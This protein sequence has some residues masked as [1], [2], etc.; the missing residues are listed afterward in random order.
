M[1]NN[2][3]IHLLSPIRPDALGRKNRRLGK[4]IVCQKEFACVPAHAVAGYDRQDDDRNLGKD[5]NCGSQADGSRLPLALLRPLAL[6][7]R[8]LHPRHQGSARLGERDTLR[9]IYDQS[10]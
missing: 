10:F 5:R 2:K 8:E 9:H 7:I 4:Q 3:R 1:E 6:E